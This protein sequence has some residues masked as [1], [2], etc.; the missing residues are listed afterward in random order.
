MLWDDRHVA[1][2]DTMLQNGFTYTQVANHFGTSKGCISGAV[3]R[4]I[5][6]NKRS[7]RT[8][9]DPEKIERLRQLL[10][11]NKTFS[12]CGD[13][14]GCSRS[15]ISGAVKRYIRPDNRG[16]KVQQLPVNRQRPAH[17]YRPK[18]NGAAHAPIEPVQWTDDVVEN[19]VALLD[20]AHHQCSWPVQGGFCGQRKSG[21]QSYCAHHAERSRPKV[22]TTV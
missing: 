19:P 20:L 3:K 2:L 21:H 18:A 11:E 22:K 1:Q 12:Q 10:R 4:H 9:D 14:L 8:W 13:I 16:N 17:V 5:T 7:R 6:H 15:S